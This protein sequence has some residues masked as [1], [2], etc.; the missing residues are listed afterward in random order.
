M[1]TSVSRLLAWVCVLGLGM[2]GIAQAQPV[3]DTSASTTLSQVDSLRAA[4]AYDAAQ[5]Q[6]AVLREEHPDDAEVLWRL[7]WTMVD[8]GEQ[9]DDEDRREQIYREALTVAQSA[10]AA[11][12]MNAD[13]HLVLG[14]TAGRVALV[15]GTR[16]KV[17]KSRTVK[18]SVDR[19]I[20][21]DSTTAAA[22]HV[23]ARWNR[24]VAT[25]GF[26]SRAAVRVVYGGLPDASLEASVRDFQRSIE[27][28]ERVIDHLELARTYLEMDDEAQARTHLQQALDTPNIDPD[29]PEHKRQARELLEDLR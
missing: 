21:L 1:N 9:I 17:E 6:L 15:S 23:R 16:E 24:E 19:A 13:A 27:L 2:A 4:G 3:P 22:Y 29:A 8:L 25:L 20:G 14:I 28:D 5:D 11:D 10:V 26:F 12:S 18:E 7:G